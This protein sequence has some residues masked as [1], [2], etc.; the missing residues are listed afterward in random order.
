MAEL[1]QTTSS[2]LSGLPV[3]PSDIHAAAETIRGAVVET[4]CSYSRTLSNICGC[5]IWLKF[6]NLQFTSSFKERGALNRL[7]ALTPEERAR[8]VIAMSAGNHAQGVAYHAKRLGIPATIVMPVGTPM[9]KVENTKHH[10]AEVVV[11]G[12]TLEEAAAY[13]AQPRRGPRHDLRPPLRRSARHRGAGH[14]RARDAEGGAGAR[15]AGGPDRRRRPDQRHRHCREIDQ[16]VGADLGVEAWLYPS[17]Y[18]A[19]HD[20][21][22]PARGDTLAEGIAVKSPGKI[23]TEIVR[24]LVDDI[25]LVNEAELERAVA[26]LISIEKTVVE[27]AGAAGLAALMSDPSRFAGQKVGLVLSGGNIDTRLIASVLTRELAREGR[28]T[29]LSLDIPDRP[30]QL[31]AVALTAGRGRRQHHRGLA[32]ADLLRPAGQ[33]DAASARHR[34]PRQRASRRGHG[35]ARRIRT[36]RALYLSGARRYRGAKPA[37]WPISR[38]ISASVL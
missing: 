32:S 21:N 37:R 28:L 18:N 14:R 7:T 12:A 13:R 22:L 31:A 33:G 36:E 9:V 2:D 19:I 8:G 15:Y 10:G 16:A 38:S 3:A 20:G 34:D 17:M 30:G 25:A 11:T 6:E 23:T 24:R 35:Q 1:S 27:G 29:Q 4:P 26:T 5:D